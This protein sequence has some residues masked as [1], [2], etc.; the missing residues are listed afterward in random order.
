LRKLIFNISLPQTEIL[1]SSLKQESMLLQICQTFPL[2]TQRCPSSSTKQTIL[3]SHSMCENLAKSKFPR[4]QL[5]A[6][7]Q[8][9]PCVH[10]KR[11]HC[12]APIEPFFHNTY[13]VAA[14]V[15]LEHLES[16]IPQNT[17]H[18]ENISKVGSNI[19]IR[20]MFPRYLNSGHIIFSSTS[21][22]TLLTNNAKT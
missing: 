3:Y 8:L 4:L 14:S 18:A 9:V 16:E 21:C 12:H 1:N 22:S 17:Y 7:Y 11:G 10:T 2:Q 15:Q 6:H 13:V 19:L 20:N 5:S